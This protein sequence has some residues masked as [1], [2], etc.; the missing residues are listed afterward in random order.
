MSRQAMRIASPV[1]VAAAVVT[2]A[3]V[4]AGDLNPPPGPIM[5]TNRV[6]LNSQAITLPHTINQGGSYVLTSDLIA[7]GP[8]SA[9]IEIGASDV[10]LDLNGFGVLGVGSGGS[11]IVASG[12]FTNIDPVAAMLNRAKFII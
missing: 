6:Q 2:V 4:G 5:S 1:L 9:G 11:G 7:S 3:W 10:S 8:G 12:A